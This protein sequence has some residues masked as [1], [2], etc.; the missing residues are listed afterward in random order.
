MFSWRKKKNIP[1]LSQEMLSYLGLCIHTKKNDPYKE[2]VAA[3]RENVF[4][5]NVD[6]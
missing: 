6:S 4:E 3:L 5:A 2:S 1:Y